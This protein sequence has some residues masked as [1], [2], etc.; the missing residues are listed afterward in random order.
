MLSIE[1]APDKITLS[2][3]MQAYVIADTTA[4][5]D[6][7]KTAL[8]VMA[9]DEAI[10]RP[11]SDAFTITFTNGLFRPITFNV[12]SD[13][14]DPPEDGISIRA[15]ATGM[16]LDEYTTRAIAD[17]LLNPTLSRFYSITKV[18]MNPGMFSIVAKKANDATYN[19][20]VEVNSD[21]P[22]TTPDMT[23]EGRG[24]LPAGY[25]Y[26]TRALITVGSSEITAGSIP[27]ELEDPTTGITRF[28]PAR[29]LEAWLDANKPFTAAYPADP[30]DTGLIARVVPI[31]SY[32]ADFRVSFDG[33]EQYNVADAETRYII[34]GALPN[35]L[36]QYLEDEE[37]TWI[38]WLGSRFLT[39]M[40][41][42][43][44]VDADEPLRLYFMVG[45]QTGS[46]MY[47]I[48]VH[49][50]S[51]SESKIWRG[52]PRS[53][54]DYHV[55][56]LCVG[57]QELPDGA[58]V[59]NA[60]GYTVTVTDG[61]NTIASGITCLIS[62]LAAL[63]D[64]T[65]LFRNGLGMPEVIRFRGDFSVQQDG[66]RFS[67][68]TDQMITAHMRNIRRQARVTTGILESQPD[69]REE[70]LRWM[71]DF[72]LSKETWLLKDGMKIPVQITNFTGINRTEYLEAS[73]D[74]RTTEQFLS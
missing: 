12:V 28:V 19:V 34:A 62:T 50:F 11:I 52:T 29:I 30:E 69:M 51:E 25:A 47:Q 10:D 36:Q 7:G 8:A 2:G 64:L 24:P 14:E 18:P 74:M 43:R 58:L 41:T 63:E 26:A 61:T 15:K 38:E 68:I 57:P 27:H 31:T 53:I 60:I 73:F 13:S 39:N 17:M 49:S 35:W 70:S 44:W 42:L 67:F 56:E 55:A 16:T 32:A 59:D 22:I 20:D 9:F 45:A 23:I 48:K 40:P 33:E 37:M 66:E 71:S 3:L 1:S 5:Q 54:D 65:F 6:A 21:A 46:P 4:Y 72:A